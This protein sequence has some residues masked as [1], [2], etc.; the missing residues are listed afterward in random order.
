MN[1]KILALPGSLRVDS[2]S[3]I[4]LKIIFEHLP[5]GVSMEI[6]D[7][8]GELP[9]FNDPKETPQVVIDFKNRIQK[10]HAVL[11]CTPEYAFGVP[12]SLKNALDWTVSTGEF[13]NK[14]VALITAASHGEKGHPALLNILTAISA[15]VPAGGDLLIN[16]VR[17]RLENNTFKNPQDLENVTLVIRSLLK[18]LVKS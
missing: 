12:G 17:A 18:A 5:E 1:T 9:H 16:F 15:N 8:I 3:N 14:P 4:V 2:S 10:A 6:F 13:V 7:G 11:I